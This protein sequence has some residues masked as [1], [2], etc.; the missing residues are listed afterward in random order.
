MNIW[1][2]SLLVFIATYVLNMF[3]I[4]VLYH[5]GLT[6][7]AVILKP[8]MRKFT[9]ATGNWVTGIDPKAWACMHR[10]H[11]EFSDTAKDPHSPWNDG[12]VGVIFAQL[13]AY[14]RTLISL[15]R[16]RA[17]YCSVVPDLDFPISWVNRRQLWWLPYLLQAVIAIALAVISHA[18]ILGVA[19]WLGMMSHPVQGWLVNSF[20]HRYGYKNFDN[21]DESRNNT[22]VAWFVMGEGYQNN[23]HA[24][25]SSARF[26]SKWYEFDSGYLLCNVARAMRLL[27]MPKTTH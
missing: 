18:W 10:R 12:V 20:A 23:H 17:E 19:Y 15:D 1:F 24:K 5:R 22:L 6:H 8:F 7:G 14:N 9:V 11:H 26:S 3:Y 25:P 16:G 4:S 27:D 13:K 21:G 2:I